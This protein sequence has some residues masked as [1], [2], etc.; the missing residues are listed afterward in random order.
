MKTAIS[1]PDPLFQ[2]ADRLARRLGISRSELYR[3]A[4]RRFLEQHSHGVVREALDDVYGEDADVSR[5][6]PAVEYLQGESLPQ[7]DW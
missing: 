1:I 5:L 2:A 3:R 7:D 6:D 4:V